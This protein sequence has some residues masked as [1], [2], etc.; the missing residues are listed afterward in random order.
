MNDIISSVTAAVG[1]TRQLV[2]LASI[3]KDAAAR[4]IIAD[5]QLEL[6]EVKI[7]L[8]AL[9]DENQQL[10][11]ELKTARLQEIDLQIRGDLYYKPDGDGPFCTCCYD[12]DHKLIRVSAMSTEFHA[13]AKFRCNS[14]KGKYQGE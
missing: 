5:L 14:C 4:S 10:K 8:A 13:I 11:G 7:R 9:I 2:D 1:L 12:R 3:A 6:A